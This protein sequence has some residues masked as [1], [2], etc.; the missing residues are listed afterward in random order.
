[1]PENLRFTPE[2]RL[3]AACSWVP[4]SDR[5]RRQRETVETLVNIEL[6]WDE[7]VSLAVRHGVVGQFCKV[8]GARGW[9]N[10]PIVA[11]EQLKSYRMVQTGSA[12]MQVSELTKIGRLFA[13]AG[14]SLIPLKGVS[15]SQCLYQDPCTRSSCDLDL[16]VKPEDVDKAERIMVQAGYR[17]ALGFHNMSRKQKHHMISTLHDHGYINDARGVHVELHWRSYLW[18]K[19]QV[20]A[21]WDTSTSSTWL[22]IGL[23]ELATEEN[24]LY[25]ADHGAQHGWPCLKW[26]SDIAMIAENMSE[27]RWHSLISKTQFYDLQRI[28]C[29]TVALLEW[30]YEIE[31]PTSVKKFLVRDSVVQKHSEYAASMLLASKDEIASRQKRFIGPRQALQIKQ[32]KPLTPLSALLRGIIVAHVDF[33]EFPLPDYL[34]WLYIPIRPYFWLR[35]HYLRR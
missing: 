2:F 4:V 22:D 25:L 35:R 12:L 1:M 26:L 13:E 28:F 34:F 3:V 17:H 31:P 15:L 24:I 32:L 14:I 33:V 19:E 29:Q 30:F 21:L 18:T 6:N 10:V 9:T 5:A 7:V 23:M 11:K 20:A 16:L 8:M 27:E